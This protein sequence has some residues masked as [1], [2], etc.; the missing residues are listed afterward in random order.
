MSLN[1]S[2]LK[3]KWKKEKDSYIKKEVG[4]GVQKFIKDVLESPD[5]FNLKQGLLSTPLDKRK[6]EFTNL[7]SRIQKTS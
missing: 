6:N 3:D 5:L 1:I 4:S 2:Q 7:K